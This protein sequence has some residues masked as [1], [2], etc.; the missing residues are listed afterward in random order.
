MGN[1][2]KDCFEAQKLAFQ[3][4]TS[5]SHPQQALLTDSGFRSHASQRLAGVCFDLLETCEREGL[6]YPVLCCRAPTNKHRVVERRADGSIVHEPYPS[7]EA[8]PDDDTV[9]I[10]VGLWFS[11]E[12]LQSIGAEAEILWPGQGQF[13]AW[14]NQRDPVSG[15]PAVWR[16]YHPYQTLM[17]RSVLDAMLHSVNVAGGLSEAAVATWGQWLQDSARSATEQLRNSQGNRFRQLAL[18]LAIED[19]YLPRVRGHTNHYG[20]GEETEP[21]D[22]WQK[23]VDREKLLE[24]TGW[25]S[26]EVVEW[27]RDL[28]VRGAMLD[29]NERF[30]MLFRGLRYDDRLKLKRDALLAW[31]YYET[32][33]LLGL[34]LHDLTGAKQANVDD[35][36]GGGQLKEKLYGIAAADIDHTTGNVLPALTRQLGIDTRPRVL[37]LVEGETEFE[38]LQRYC[39]L[40]EIDLKASLVQCQHISGINRA[41]D[42]N[43][44]AFVK[45]AVC[46]ESA[47]VITIDNEKGAGDIVRLLKAQRIADTQRGIGDLDQDDLFWGVFVWPTNLENGNFSAGQ[48]FDA[49]LLA[50][51]QGDEGTGTPLPKDEWRAEFVAFAGERVAMAPLELVHAFAKAKQMRPEKRGVGAFLPDVLAAE[52]SE[53][54]ELPLLPIEKLLN[55][56]L[57]LAWRLRN[58]RMVHE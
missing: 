41:S 57:P 30:Y 28:A 36:W 15:M 16:R 18:L 14:K 9:E 58:G 22:D 45:Q 52:R 35:L 11:A 51:S 55:K 7:E 20:F 31:D 27:R 47:V 6:L 48:L 54:P 43:L 4:L 37:W 5:K 10:P 49:W 40:A 17:L 29:P 8:K 32:A 38:F 13:V 3:I 19:L 34:L 2:F 46:W 39:E 25:S 24:M 33:E 12:V 26:A 53:H 23:G 44:I 1:A 50:V 56:V 21:W 42:P